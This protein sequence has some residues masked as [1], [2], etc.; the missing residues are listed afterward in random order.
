ME[1]THRH[2]D[3]AQSFGTDAELYDRARPSYPA[4]L[5]SEIIDASPGLDF[6]DVGIGTGL[7]ARLFRD[8]GCRVLGVEVDER[9]AEV[10]R[11]HGFE[12]EASAFETWD[13]A[14]RQFDAVTAAQAWH[15]IDPLAGAAK[16]AEALREGGVL[17]VFW[18][19]FGLSQQ[20]ADAF[21]DVYRQVPNDLPFNPWAA[22]AL[23]NYE[24]MAQVA[25]DGMRKTGK[26]EEPQE[27]RVDWQ[28]RS[29][30]EEWL[31]QVPTFGGHSRLPK[32]QLDALLAGLGAVTPDTIDVNY[33]TVAMLA[34]KMPSTSCDIKRENT[35]RADPSAS[36]RVTTSG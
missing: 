3:V 19:A 7:S 8:A 10:A 2:R 5:V 14:G 31:S 28:H 30:R 15:W 29:T 26:F 20:L 35:Y 23:P 27:F 33:T 18:N 12:V 21:A 16:A 6:L 1:A 9:M 11:R 13:P 4:E 25:A 24:K 34:R 22:P 36:T 32:T 17:A